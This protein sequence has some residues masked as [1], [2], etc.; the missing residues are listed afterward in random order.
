MRQ[1]SPGPD[2]R[3][4]IPRDDIPPATAA[5]FFNHEHIT[6]SVMAAKPPAEGEDSGD[7]DYP[8]LLCQ[9]AHVGSFNNLVSSQ[10]TIRSTSPCH[11]R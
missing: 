5:G 3:H 4:A 1:R 6:Y 11:P 9:K 10:D 2:N 7:T 8:A